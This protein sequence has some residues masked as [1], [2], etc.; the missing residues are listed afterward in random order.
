MNIDMIFCNTWISLKIPS[1]LFMLW[2]TKQIISIKT[3]IQWID[4]AKTILNLNYWSPPLHVYMYV[5]ISY[6]D[7]MLSISI[8]HLLA[9]KSTFYTCKCLH[10]KIHKHHDQH[11]LPFKFYPTTAHLYIKGW[12][13][14]T[15][16]HPVDALDGFGG[17]LAARDRGGG[18][19]WAVPLQLQ[20]LVTHGWDHAATK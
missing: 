2:H 20:V 5:F 4:D 3:N 9:D 12:M 1:I 13:L 19:L 15:A 17:G 10:I 14:V 18:G 11:R 8:S 7:K 16:Q 6:H